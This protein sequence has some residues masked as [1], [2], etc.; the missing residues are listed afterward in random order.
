MALIES[1]KKPITFRGKTVDELKTLETR[2]FARYLKSRQRRT[3]LKQFQD[4]ENFINRA[5]KKL[6]KNK[7]VRTHLRTLVIV[8]QMVG[9][10]IHVYN[11]KEFFP[12]EITGQMLGHRFGEFALTRGKVKHSSAGKGATKSS[13]S[14]TK[15]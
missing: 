7:P 6:E 5:K 14:I 8:P 10:K 3:V 4:I 2:E 11:G 12:I 1:S 9:M 15:K 13:K